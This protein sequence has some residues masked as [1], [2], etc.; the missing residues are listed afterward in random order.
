MGGRN[1]SLNLNLVSLT[2]AA[3]Q[4]A[5]LSF[6]PC[7]RK[8]IKTNELMKCRVKNQPNMSKCHKK[9][10]SQE[11]KNQKFTRN[12]IWLAII[13]NNKR[14]E[15]KNLPPHNSV[16]SFPG[17]HSKKD[18]LHI[19]Q[20][21]PSPSISGLFTVF[22]KMQTTEEPPIQLNLNIIESLKVTA[23]DS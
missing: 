14:K 9:Y 15:K 13:I 3:H 6:H 7:K 17:Y 23:S 19:L 22:S 1:L 12:G 20:K 8:K 10:C 2:L 18:K 21:I 5:A 16:R 4:H 11:R